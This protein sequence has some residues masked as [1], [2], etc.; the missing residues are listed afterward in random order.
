MRDL[1]KKKRVIESCYTFNEDVKQALNAG[2]HKKLREL[3]VIIFDLAIRT[4]LQSLHHNGSQLS[5][6]STDLS[7]ESTVRRSARPIS[8]ACED[9]IT[10]R[11]AGS[12]PSQNGIAVKD[13]GQFG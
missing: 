11:P 2:F 5:S 7:G 12:S 4:F 13:D 10:A 8:F 3:L 9:V 6:S 1:K